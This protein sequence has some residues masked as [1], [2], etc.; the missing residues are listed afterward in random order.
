MKGVKPVNCWDINHTT[1][2]LEIRYDEKGSAVGLHPLAGRDSKLCARLW[3]S[4]FCKEIWGGGERGGGGE[5]GAGG[6]S[7]V[8]GPR[9]PPGGG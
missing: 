7:G 9:A 4:L 3:W 6:G 8:Y 5:G 1:D 2:L